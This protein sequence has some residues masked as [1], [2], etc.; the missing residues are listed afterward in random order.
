MNELI[1]RS[2]KDYKIYTYDEKYIK[3]G[4]KILNKDYKI[5]EIYKDTNR[6]YVGKIEI[7]EKFYVLKSP[8]SEVIIPQRKILSMFKRGEVLST[9]KN[10]N[11]GIDEGITEYVKPLL[12]IVKKGLFIKESFLLMEY[13]P[14]ERLRT[15]E[16]V[17]KVIELTKKIHRNKRYHGDLNT[18]NFIKVGENIKIIDT[19]GKRDIFFGF[20]RAYDILTLKKDLLVLELNYNVDENYKIDKSIGYYLAYFLKEGKNLKFIQKFRDLKKR[21]RKK[22]WKI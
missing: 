19:Q 15:I 20:K 4:E 22:G 2:Y 8:K 1:E 17:D 18:S 7:D 13:L 14:G 10:L 11:E 6:N 5:I 12:G 3:I 21:L 16:D 9:L